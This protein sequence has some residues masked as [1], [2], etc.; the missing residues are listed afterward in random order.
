[1]STTTKTVQDNLGARMRNA[2]LLALWRAVR[3]DKLAILGLLI[4]L[5]YFVMAIFADQIA[6]YNPQSILLD[7]VTGETAEYR[8]PSPQYLFGTNN[9][10]RDI[11]SQ[12]VYGSRVA[13]LVGFV[14]AIVVTFIG[15][16]VGLI[17]GY[18]GG[19]VDDLLM[20]IVD[21]AYA[22]PFVPFGVLLVG[23]L[24]PSTLNL[25]LT[26]AL[27]MWRAPARVVRAQVLTLAQRPFVKAARV[28]GASNLRI[29]FMH[30]APN[31][32]PIVFLYIPVSVGYA[33]M[34]EASLSFLGFG[35]PRQ[36]SWGGI[37]Q[38]AFTS[39]AMRL[40]W[41]WTLAPGIAIVSMVM[42]VFFISRAIEPLANPNLLD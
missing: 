30:L 32:L 34:A 6:P 23:L 26:V 39:G 41:W 17:S 36:L 4:L 37:L 3:R 21:V 1:M 18:Y 20:R 11:F 13:L 33:I 2:Q 19:W 7:P 14:S 9:L 15:A 24:G 28:A 31:V 22:I 38:I 42:A 10:A 5:M 29:I 27:I 16:A 25:T 12:V 40:A 8:P 35:D